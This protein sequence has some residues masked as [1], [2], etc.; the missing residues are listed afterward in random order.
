MAAL[1]FSGYPRAHMTSAHRT[2][3]LVGALLALAGCNEN[4]QHNL[5]EQDA[6]DIMVLLQE[7]GIGAKKVREEGGNEPTYVIQVPRQDYAQAA[8][9]LREH[10]LPRPHSDGLGSFAKNKGM[11]PTQT[12]ER[13]MFLD[14]IAGEVSN[15]LNTVPG[16]LEARAIVMIPENS[17]LAQPDKRPLPSASVLVKYRNALDGAPPIDEA[18]V[19][20]FVSTVVTDLKPD[21]VTVIMTQAQ[22]PTGVDP[23]GRFKSV[24][25]M[26]IAAESESQFKW[27]VA[28]GGLVILGL[29]VFA[30]WTL[31]R[32]GSSNRGRARARAES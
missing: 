14:A 30:S 25:G 28:I 22:P 9:L 20:A 6:N 13:A 5:P 8:K 10:S 11:I 17:D 1:S 27:M 32:G 16:V 26:T 12:E 4:L 18:R 15:A 21:N 29:S 31:A 3:L 2:L 23:G 7:S 24:L 19:K